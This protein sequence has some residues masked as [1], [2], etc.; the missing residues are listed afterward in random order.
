MRVSDIEIQS[1]VGLQDGKPVLIVTVEAVS[2]GDGDGQDGQ[3][4]KA[5]GG[6]SP[7]DARKMAAQWLEAAEAAESDAAVL[8]ELRLCGVPDEVIAEFMNA[9][10]HRRDESVSS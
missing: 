3:G 2:D 4:F 7:S 8:A 5:Q 1:A 6:L 10:R 9:M